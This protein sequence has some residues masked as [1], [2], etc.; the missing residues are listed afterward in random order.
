MRSPRPHYLLL[1]A[2]SF[3]L[4]ICIAE[5]RRGG[6]GGSSGDSGGS[7]GD[8]DSNSD[9][10]PSVCVNDGLPMITDLDIWR[11]DNY[12]SDPHYGGAYF[13]GEAS[14]KVEVKQGNLYTQDFC[15]PTAGLTLPD[16]LF[17]AALIA[18]QSPW[19]QGSH[20]SIVIG[21]KGWVTNNSTKDFMTSYENCDAYQYAINFRTSSYYTMT[22]EY[23][24]LTGVCDSV[25]LT[26]SPGENSTT[27]KGEY[28]EMPPTEWHNVSMGQWLYDEVVFT[29]SLCGQEGL[30]EAPIPI[31]MAINGSV[32]SDTFNLTITGLD[33]NVVYGVNASFA[34]DFKGTFAS[35]NSTQ[36]VKVGENDDSLIS[37]A[38]A[39]EN[40]QRKPSA[41]G[42][43]IFS[44]IVV[45]LSYGYL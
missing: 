5:A 36:I 1:L 28:I 21:F 27:F 24:G 39:G 19:P 45:V 14:Y 44:V 2:I 18:P 35:A 3:Q 40:G 20:N 16:R 6:G 34:I 32:N 41:F 25:P 30:L 31:G 42:P 37:F 33:I 29:G 4:L 17:A 26:I 23:D 9:G 13:F 11:F 43:A 10:A 8:D 22:Y 7:S 15:T 12:S 38:V